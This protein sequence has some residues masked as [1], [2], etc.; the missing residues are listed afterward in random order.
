M[1]KEN[2]EDPDI[3]LLEME[4]KHRF[5][6][7]EDLKK[8]YGSVFRAVDGINCRMYEGQ[9]FALL[10]HNGAGKTTTLH[11]LTGM[12]T[13]SDGKAVVYGYNTFG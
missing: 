11:M 10:G 13:P 1:K 9:I 2:F 5:L 6:K 3:A 7:I 8:T 4:K 12:T